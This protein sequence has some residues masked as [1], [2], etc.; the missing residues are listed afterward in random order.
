[1]VQKTFRKKFPTPA[2]GGKGGA[3]AGLRKPSKPISVPS[4]Q[5][6]K[7]KKGY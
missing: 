4:A 5:K 6:K 7:S 3:A 2:A 1:M